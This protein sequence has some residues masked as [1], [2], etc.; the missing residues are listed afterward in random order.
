M[1]NMKIYV[2]VL[3]VLFFVC[4]N[5]KT[6]DSEALKSPSFKP[7]NIIVILD[8]SDRVSKQMHHSQE[9]RDKYVVEEI[10]KQF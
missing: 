7:K 3:C 10:V 5:V 1:V 4:L 6:S 2:N 9:E 8:T